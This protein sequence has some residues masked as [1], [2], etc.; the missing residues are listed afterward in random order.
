MD[1]EQKYTEDKYVIE[2]QVLT[3]IEDVLSADECDEFADLLEA[4]SERLHST[5]GDC[6]IKLGGVLK[7]QVFFETSLVRVT[8]SP[9]LIVRFSLTDIDNYLD[10]MLEKTVWEKPTEHP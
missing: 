10:H 1:L 6:M 8:P 3:Y 9:I 7:S 5:M 2:E 4:N